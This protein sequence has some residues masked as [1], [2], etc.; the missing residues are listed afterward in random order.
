MQE[1][2][3]GSALPAP[4]LEVVAAARVRPAPVH[5]PG[6]RHR[7]GDD[8]PAAGPPAGRTPGPLCC[9]C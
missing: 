4:H 8:R 7:Q 3:M 9:L 6:R 2:V 5:S 1:E